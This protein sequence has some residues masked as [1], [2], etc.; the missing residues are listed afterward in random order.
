M[1]TLP[2]NEFDLEKLFLPAWAQEPS[3]AKYAHYEGEEQRVERRLERRGPRPPRREGPPSQ[4][5]DENRPRR[6]G[7]PGSPR[8]ETGRDR[9]APGGRGPLRRPEPREQ[10]EPPPPLPEINVSLLPD[11]KGVESLAR[12]IKMTGRAYPLFDIAQMILQK[13]ERHAAVFSV[14]K[15]AEGK[16]VQPLFVC[17][18]DDTLWLSDD[19]ASA[20]ALKKHFA[21]FYQ[22]ERT[23]KE[24]PKGTY[25]FVAQCGLSGVILGPPNY[26]DYQNQLRK[27]HAERFSRMPFEAFKARVRIVRDG[28]VV[29]KWI[30]DQSWRTEYNCLNLP[31]SL[32]LGTMEEVET[33]FRQTHKENIIKAVESHTMTGAAARALRSPELLRLIRSVW[34]DQRRFPLQIATVLSQQFATHGLQFFKVNKTITHVCVTRPHYLDLA[35]APVSEGVKHIVD[36]IN[37]HAKCT[38]RDLVEA[39]A[40]SPAPAPISLPLPAPATAPQDAA[41]APAQAPA[42]GPQFDANQPTPEQTVVIADLHWLIHQGH[43]IEF[44]NGFLETAKKPVPKPPKPEP[45]PPE[46]AAPAEPQP[47]APQLPPA[48]EA[49]APQDSPPVSPAQVEPL[50][51]PP[52]TEAPASDP[53]P[54]PP[55]LLEPLPPPAST[56]SQT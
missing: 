9:L 10:H 48:T 21:T 41:P 26:H 12:Q 34:E 56:Q 22:A 29:K 7:R 28:E 47:A 6:E 20:Y 44:A 17:A 45:K 24:P 52:A 8:P 16:P 37:S 3:S 42:P 31:E 43:V 25:T 46:P 40:P 55:A 5:R 35:A 27:L 18:L 2:D 19:E 38:R 49:P 23:P 14:K 54:P 32:R 39:L 11:E 51:P 50:Q 30:E 53:Q 13:P 36:L 33:H 1:S 4:R 15:N